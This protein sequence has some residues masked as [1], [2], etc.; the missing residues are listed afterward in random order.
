MKLKYLVYLLPFLFACCDECPKQFLND[1]ALIVLKEDISPNQE[2]RILTYQFDTGALGYSRIFWAVLP[3]QFD[4]K[5]EMNDFILPDGYKAV[6]WSDKSE[7]ILE[8]WEPYYYKDKKVDLV[9]GDRWNT[10]KVIVKE[11]VLAK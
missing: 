2:N 5:K 10:I 1:E 9:T 8:K 4:E 6:R 7:L 11:A 3:H